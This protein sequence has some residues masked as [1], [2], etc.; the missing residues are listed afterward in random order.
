MSFASILGG[1][2]GGARFNLLP[3]YYDQYVPLSF[4]GAF[5]SCNYLASAI[6]FRVS[7]WFMKH[8]KP[9]NI[10][11]TSEIYSRMMSLVALASSTITAP[12]AMALSAITYGPQ[13]VAMQH[14]LHEDFTDA[15]RATMTSLNSLLTSIMYAIFLVITGYIAD[16][17]GLIAAFLLCNV[18]LLPIIFMYR[19]VFR[20]ALK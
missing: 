3:A 6:G 15:Q 13:D 9:I 12:I 7:N 20:D 18:C 5:V 19:S 16:R 14:L 10:L 4:V 1:G 11:L 2:V 8:F 17:Y